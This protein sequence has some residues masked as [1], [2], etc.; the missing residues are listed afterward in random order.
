MQEANVKRTKSKQKFTDIASSASM[1]W[2]SMS[3]AVLPVVIIVVSIFVA[4]IGYSL[5][6][7]NLATS[8]DR[9]VANRFRENELRVGGIFDS[10]AHLLWGSTG[11]MQSAEANE[12]EWRQFIWAFNLRKNFSGIEA[13]GL[14]QGNTLDTQVLTLA[15]PRTAH[16]DET[17]GTNMSNMPILRDA[18]GESARTGDTRISGP[19]P[20]LFSTKDE[21]KNR[22]TGFVM[23]APYYEKTLPE[24]TPEER[25]AVLRGYTVAAFRGDIFFNKAFQNAD[26]RHTKIDIYIDDTHPSH[27]LHS[28]GAT[29]DNQTQTETQEL[30]FYGEKFIFVYTFDTQHMLSWTLTYMPHI[31]L[32]SMLILGLLF[33]GV[34][35]Y[36]L[37]TRYMRLTFEKERDVNFAKDELLSLASHQLRTPATGVKQYLGM[38]LQGF[39]GDVPDKQ[40]SYL[41]KAY[42]SNNRQLHVINDILHLAK[43][44]TGRIVLAE[45]KFDIAKM[46]RG[47]VDEQRDQ[48][49]K[50]KITVRLSAP[51]QGWIMGDS[52]MLWMVMENL[53]SNAIKYTPENGTVTIRLAR[54]GNKWVLTVKDT[55]VG[56]DKKDFSKLFKQFSRITN[57]RSDFVTGT[58]VG[59]Y[60]AHHL[61]VLHGG[62]IGVSSVKSKGTTF[63]VRLPRKL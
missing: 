27:L 16:T 42:A 13:L 61:T 46:L 20:G 30:E 41:E 60:L 14:T 31:I 19:I 49:E 24:A 6:S 38:V 52:H 54:R 15:S 57:S 50:G 45:R 5:M 51:G 33:A 11:R 1:R 39:A 22:A 56:I 26:L 21:V 7:V 59:L 9:Y 58:G 8:R 48:A 44:E 28:V 2:P 25:L 32:I 55:G 18:I 12:S 62:S 23:I 17:I 63:T 43:L 47:V 35:G 10:Y 53:V 37:R 3:Y 29:T 34:A 40:R 4:L 36:L